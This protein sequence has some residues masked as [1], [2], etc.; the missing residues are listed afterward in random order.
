MIL[1]MNL[2][3]L[4]WAY[5]S[6]L[7]YYAL[8]YFDH[9][10]YILTVYY[11]L[12]NHRVLLIM[13]NFTIHHLISRDITNFYY[14]KILSNIKIS[15]SRYHYV[16]PWGIKCW[17]VKLLINYMFCEYIFLITID[18]YARIKHIHGL[19]TSCTLQFFV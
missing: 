17:M 11:L 8:I 12:C 1:I 5:N 9:E 19:T 10:L 6:F 3:C 18:I 14:L 15:T 7:V 16:V 2:F 4:R 13:S